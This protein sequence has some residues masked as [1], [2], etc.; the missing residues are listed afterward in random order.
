MEAG[1]HDD[2]PGLK[3]LLKCGEPLIIQDTKKLTQYAE[4][5]PEKKINS[6]YA[7]PMLVEGNLLGTV[8]ICLPQRNALSEEYRDLLKTIANQA[9][10]AIQRARLF[11]HTLRSANKMSALYDVGLHTGSTFSF[12]EVLKRTTKNKAKL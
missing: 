2:M 12:S 3:E 8:C 9:G 5:I 7:F 6:L 1:S 11:Q 10:V 4:L